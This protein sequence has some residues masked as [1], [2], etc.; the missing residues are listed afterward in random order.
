MVH[1]QDSA[2]ELMPFLYSNEWFRQET[3]IP[4]S[5]ENARDLK[6]FGIQS[7]VRQ[8]DI[9]TILQGTYAYDVRR[10][11]K[12]LLLSFKLKEETLKYLLFHCTENVN[13]FG[14]TQ[15][16]I[17]HMCATLQLHYTCDSNRSIGRKMSILFKY[18]LKHI[19]KHL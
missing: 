11:S 9:P 2:F 6:C 7:L 3:A 10:T 19:C 13:G 17:S 15:K 18:L 8:L 14:R 4:K 16:V 5:R 1:V 12:F